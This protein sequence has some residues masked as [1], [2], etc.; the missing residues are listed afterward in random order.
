MRIHHIALRTDD[1]AAL[2][3]FYVDVFEMKVLRDQHP[4]TIWLELDRGALMIERR[5]PDEPS[6]AEGS[7]ELL[8]FVADETHRDAVAE[9][10]CARGCD[11]GA[12][13]HTRYLRDPDGRRVAVSSYPFD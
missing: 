13:E 7:L 4:Q 11:D 6:V 1:V 9:R 3:R 2:A 8:A 12:T 5:G 10:A